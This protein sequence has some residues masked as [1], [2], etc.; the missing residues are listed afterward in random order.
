MTKN[1]ANIQITVVENT[2]RFHSIAI[3]KSLK[4]IQFYEILLGLKLNYYSQHFDSIAILW[5]QLQKEWIL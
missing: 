1:F 3:R 2:S 5:N 4:A